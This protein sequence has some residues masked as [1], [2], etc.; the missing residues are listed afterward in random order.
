MAVWLPRR[1]DGV[2]LPPEPTLATG[3]RASASHHFELD[4]LVALNDGLHPEASGDHA[5]P[6]HTFWPH[7]GGEEWLRYDFAAP[8]TIAAV[9]VYWFD[10]TGVGR[11][12]VP[13]RAQ[14]EWLDASGAWQ[15]VNAIVPL[16]VAKD[17][18]NEQSFAPVATTALRLRIRLQSDGSAGVLEWEVR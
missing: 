9:R 2:R 17:A 18:W 10:D 5:I 15:P 1:P 14:V 12:R 13:G 3:A 8:T 4:T 6:R 11:C 16:G 7:V